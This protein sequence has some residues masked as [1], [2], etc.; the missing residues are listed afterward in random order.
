[1]EAGLEIGRVSQKHG[2]VLDTIV[3]RPDVFELEQK[4]SDEGTNVYNRDMSWVGDSHYVIVDGTIPSTGVGREIERA[5]KIHHTPTL[6]LY[7]K[8]RL[9][10]VTRMIS[11]DAI[12]DPNIVVQCYKNIGDIESIVDK[13]VEEKKFWIN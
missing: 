10:M 1:M 8:D 9:K 11:H 6:F 12:Q 2:S 4:N 13:F 5:V 3:L 7:N